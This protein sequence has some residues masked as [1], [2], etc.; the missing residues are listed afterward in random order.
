VHLSK[1]RAVAIAVQRV[2]MLFTRH[3]NLTH[4]GLSNSSAFISYFMHI[5]SIA[6]S[7]GQKEKRR[8]IATAIAL[9]LTLVKT[10]RLDVNR[11]IF[12]CDGARL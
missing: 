9:T 4:N 8:A 1:R 2:A 7:C 5:A 10:A 11:E 3:I 12:W 6:S